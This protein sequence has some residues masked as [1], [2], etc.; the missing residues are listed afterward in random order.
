MRKQIVCVSPKGEVNICWLSFQPDGSI[1]FGLNDRT[2][3]AP[4]MMGRYN[5]FNAYNRVRSEFI[6]SSGGVGM[7]AVHNPHFTYHPIAHFHLTGNDGHRLF[8][9]IADTSIVLSQQHVLPWIRA[10]SRAIA[11]LPKAQTRADGIE[12]ERLCFHLADAQVSL[13]IAVDLLRP[14]PW[15]QAAGALLCTLCEWQG[16]IACLAVTSTEGQAPTLSWFHET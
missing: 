12:T 1:S 5:V 3:I 7:E 6:V 8:E 10:T 4:A 9:G 2:F 16:V 15:A 11:L 14:G 13:R